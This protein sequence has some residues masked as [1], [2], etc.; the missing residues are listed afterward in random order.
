MNS[1]RALLTSRVGLAAIVSVALFLF[2][3]A[4]NRPA[5]WLVTGEGR[6]PIA[7]AE[8]R[9]PAPELQAP[10]SIPWARQILRASAVAPIE[11]ETDAPPGVPYAGAVLAAR[12]EA[13]ADLRRQADELPAVVDKNLAEFAKEN[14]PVARALEAALASAE[15]DLRADWDEGDVS[16]AL[17][18]RL[19]GLAAAVLSSGGGVRAELVQPTDGRED[20]QA[21]LTAQREALR[22]ARADLI[23]QIQL[24]PLDSKTRMGDL[25]HRNAVMAEACSRA[26]RAARTLRS[27]ELPTGEWIVVLELDI[28][29]LLGV[30]D[31]LP[32]EK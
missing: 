17:E 22:R 4:A 30:A 16:I 15:E 3:C 29:P 32:E 25:M 6:A 26:I 19:G 5:T 14:P 28:A 7:G 11:G 9:T 10:V 24:V 31:S 21:Q 2:G 1:P 23:D 20:A 18:M 27:E 8:T 13:Q 12:G